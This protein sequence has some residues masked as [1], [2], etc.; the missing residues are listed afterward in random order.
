M[1]TMPDKRYDAGAEVPPLLA[2][3]ATPD[4]LCFATPVDVYIGYGSQRHVYPRDSV[5]KREEILT[6]SLAYLDD[7]VSLYTVPYENLR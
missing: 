3:E 7:T 1:E 2:A 5:E 6:G 4:G